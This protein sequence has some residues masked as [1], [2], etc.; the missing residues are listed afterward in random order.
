MERKIIVYGHGGDKRPGFGFPTEA[1][2][3]QWIKEDISSKY[4]N[5]YHYTLG[6]DADVIVLSREGKAYGHFETDGKVDPNPE[7]LRGLPRIEIRL[8]RMRS[9]TLYEKPGSIDGPWD[10]G[11]EHGENHHGRAV[12][13]NQE[14]GR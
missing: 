14:S 6:M 10:Q 1:D 2:F 8:Q 7:G 4:Q 13:R 12:R 3:Q 9:R 5:R 11:R